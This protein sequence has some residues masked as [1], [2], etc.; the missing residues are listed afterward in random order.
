MS[1]ENWPECRHETLAT[2]TKTKNVRRGDHKKLD[3]RGLLLN[4]LAD[5]L[6][7]EIRAKQV[8]DE[9]FAVAI[10]LTSRLVLENGLVVPPTQI[11]ST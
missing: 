1:G 10:F 7:V 2:G 8:V 3:T 6:F 4:I 11:L 5:K 9:A